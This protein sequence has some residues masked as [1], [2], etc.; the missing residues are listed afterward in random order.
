M[1]DRAGWRVRHKVK[2]RRVISFDG[3][4]TLWDFDAAQRQALSKVRDA[5]S[6]YSPVRDI[7]NVDRMIAIRAQV[8]EELGEETASLRAM[9]REG[10]RRAVVEAGISP[11]EEFLDELFETFM[12]ARDEA[13]TP[14]PDVVS[15]LRNVKSSGWTTALLTNGN[16]NTEAAGLAEHFDHLL[17]AED[18]GVRK[19]NRGAF[20]AVS[21]AASCELADIVHVGDSL[22]HDVAGASQAG[23]TA[24]WLNRDGLKNP[25]AVEPDYE[26]STLSELPGI[27]E[28]IT[29]ER[30]L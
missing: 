8:G 22:E 9:R 29:K 12:T 24:I 3:D 21:R 19:P 10:I 4:N 25:G 28:E 17:Y 5:I 13:I 6:G 14:Y 30:G 2:P 16:A 26:I 1:A 27:L 23:A 20:E 11:P 18:I 15:A 7:P